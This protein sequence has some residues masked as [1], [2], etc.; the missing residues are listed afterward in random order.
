MLAIKLVQEY[1]VPI[2]VAHGLVRRYGGRA[3]DVLEV[4]VETEMEQ[5]RRG[6]QDYSSAVHEGRRLCELRLLVPGYTYIE[7]EVVYAVRYEWA[8]HAEDILGMWTLLQIYDVSLCQ[9][10]LY[11]TL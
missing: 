11:F 5:I 4:A 8:A 9:R 7:A 1:H 10:A 2:A 3:R 6:L